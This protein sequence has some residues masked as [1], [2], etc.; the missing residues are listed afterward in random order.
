[1]LESFLDC[2][3]HDAITY[4]LISPNV[5]SHTKLFLFFGGD[6]LV[7]I[8]MRSGE[9]YKFD[10]KD[11]EEDLKASGFP[12]RVAEEV[13][14]R[15]EDRV[16]DRWTS[17]KVNQQVDLELKRLEEDMQRAHSSYKEKMM[18][19][20]MRTEDKTRFPEDTERTSKVH[21]GSE[22]FIPETERE[23]HRSPF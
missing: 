5:S 21:N 7:K 22:T 6:F 19:R 4:L 1:M 23:R 20:E 8:V 12:E 13:A 16:E 18:E 15:V 17:T 14:E 10:S 11:V 9:E 3:F 2:C